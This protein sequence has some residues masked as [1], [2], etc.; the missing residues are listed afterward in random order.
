MRILLNFITSLQ[1]L[2]KYF[3]NITFHLTMKTHA[4][5]GSQGLLTWEV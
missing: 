4:Y 1:I 3:D 5:K 2:L